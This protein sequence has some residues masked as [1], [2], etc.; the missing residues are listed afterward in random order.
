MQS[1]RQ[2]VDVAPTATGTPIIASPAPRPDQRAVRPVPSVS[3]VVATRN[4]AMLLRRCLAS[5]QAQTYPRDR[6]EIIVVDDGSTDGTPEEAAALAQAWEGTLRVLRMAHGGPARARNAGIRASRAE[7][8]AFTDSDCGVAA[9]WLQQLVRTLEHDAGDGVGGP[10]VT[11]ATRSWVARYLDAAAFYRHR[12]RHGQIDYLLTASAAFRRAA[13][14]AVGGFSERAGAWGEDA[15]LSFRLRRYGY[16][17]LLAPK[18]IVTHY[19]MP[20]GLR[21][22][23][24]EL[25]RYG[26]GNYLLSRDW[27][28]GRTPLRELARHGGAVLLAPL[29]ALYYARRPGLR[30]A[31][32][33]WPLIVTEHLAFSAGLLGGWLHGHVWGDRHGERDIR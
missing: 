9:N 14:E 22:L 29:L 6:Y 20:V 26:R 27:Y 18:G 32:V 17:L 3:V 15:D 28:N 31:P 4:R 21:G 2:Q 19:G 5:L 11:A 13:L 24:V 25:Y 12:V 8:V 33:F 30:W 7:I 1:W 16:R 23:A 10:I